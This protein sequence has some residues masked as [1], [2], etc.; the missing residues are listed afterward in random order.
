MGS[1]HVRGALADVAIDELADLVRCLPLETGVIDLA[2]FM[3]KLEAMGYDGP[4]TTEPF[5]AHIN[6]VAAEDSLAAAREVS[7]AMDKLWQ[8]AGIGA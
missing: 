2:T 4:V 5:S 3:R 8:A 6:A 7:A 1:E